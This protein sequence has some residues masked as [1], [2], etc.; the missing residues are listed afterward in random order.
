MR[1]GNAARLLLK[2]LLGVLG[3]SAALICLSILF[4]GAQFTA[5]TAESMFNFVTGANHPF[6]EPWPA[7]ADSELRFYAPFWGAYGMLA[8]WLAFRLEAR[9]TRV[10]GGG[11]VLFAGGVGRLISTVRVGP[12][13]PARE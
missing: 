4:T 12:P 5:W 8:T 3:I 13:H 2:I 11:L 7:T 1:G 9:P 6:S 10:R